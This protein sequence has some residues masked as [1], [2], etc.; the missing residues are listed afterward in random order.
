MKPTM[1]MR[2]REATSAPVTANTAVP[3]QSNVTRNVSSIEVSGNGWRPRGTAIVE[4]GSEP[5][6]GTGDD[7]RG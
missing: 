1:S 4:A 3:N 6:N 7:R 5:G 2:L